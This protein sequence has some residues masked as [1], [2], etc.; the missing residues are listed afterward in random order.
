[1][2]VR[3]VG[4]VF[5][6]AETA[7]DGKAFTAGEVSCH[8]SGVD[9]LIGL[10]VIVRV[11][12]IIDD[13]AGRLEDLPI[14]PRNGRHR[15]GLRISEPV[16]EFVGLMDVDVRGLGAHRFEFLV[17]LDG[18][19]SLGVPEALVVGVPRGDRGRGG[20]HEGAHEDALRIGLGQP[21]TDGFDEEHPSTEV[22]HD[23]E[24]DSRH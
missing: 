18:Q 1:M 7:I 21:G 22:Q 2:A 12:E 11:G 15:H 9:A 10:L 24:Q 19:Q 5:G 23:P 4:A 16:G 13:F 17:G 3:E 20:Q 14:Q 8:R 6:D